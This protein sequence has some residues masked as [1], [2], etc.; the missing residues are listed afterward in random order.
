V[1]LI[2]RL[3]KENW[4]LLYSSATPGVTDRET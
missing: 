3:R 4:H 2:E 1:S